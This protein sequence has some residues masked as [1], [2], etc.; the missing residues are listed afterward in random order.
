MILLVVASVGNG[1]G[2]AAASVR[3][4]QTAIW[5]RPRFAH[6]AYGIA[7]N[8]CSV[9]LDLALRVVREP[10]RA[11]LDHLDAVQQ[12]RRGTPS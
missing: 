6:V 5:P 9:F 4:S 10:E 12:V 8:G 7:M 1:V 2:R 11:S 3:A